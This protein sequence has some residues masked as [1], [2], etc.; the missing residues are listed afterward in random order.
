[1]KLNCIHQYKLLRDIKKKVAKSDELLLDE[2]SSLDFYH[3]CFFINTLC[4]SEKAI[5]AGVTLVNNL[6]IQKNMDCPSIADTMASLRDF[7]LDNQDEVVKLL[8]RN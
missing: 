7:V 5:D 2:D 4:N 8:N 1:M 3:W 6:E